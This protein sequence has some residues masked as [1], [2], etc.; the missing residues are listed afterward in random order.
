M[1]CQKDSSPAGVAAEL[2]LSGK[3]FVDS[4]QNCSSPEKYLLTDRTV[5]KNFPE[6]YS[7]AATAGVELSVG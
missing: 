4:P 6:S 5:N 3:I 7:S 2:E 1:M